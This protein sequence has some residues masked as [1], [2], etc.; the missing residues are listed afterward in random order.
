MKLW[1]E[2]SINFYWTDHKLILGVGCF[3]HAE[4]KLFSAYTIELIF[5]RWIFFINFTTNYKEYKKFYDK[6][7]R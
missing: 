7:I 3:K 2:K 1:F 6:R 4:K 5:I